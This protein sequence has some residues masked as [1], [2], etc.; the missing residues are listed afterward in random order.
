MRYHLVR[1]DFVSVSPLDKALVYGGRS[2]RSV[3]SEARNNSELVRPTLVGTGGQLPP[4]RHQQ[5]HLKNRLGTAHGSEDSRRK[6]G[7]RIQGLHQQ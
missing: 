5:E 1:G 4:S 2:D 6:G 7:D 3:V